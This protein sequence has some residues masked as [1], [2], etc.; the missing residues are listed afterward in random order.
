MPKDVHTVPDPD[1]GEGWAN[2]FGGTVQSR[3]RRKEVAIMEGRRM[4][5]RHRCEHFIHNKDGTIA[6]KNSYGPDPL[7]PKD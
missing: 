3:H 4:A 5:K 7:P 1:G 2:E 6:E